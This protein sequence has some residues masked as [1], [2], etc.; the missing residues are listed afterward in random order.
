MIRTHVSVKNITDTIISSQIKLFTTFRHNGPFVVID[1]SRQNESI[2]SSTVCI[3]FECKEN[4]NEYYC[5][6]IHD[7]V[8][9]YNPLT[10]VE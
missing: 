6:I 2:K 5:L 1:C 3:E 4:T 10:N 8:V 9:Q 7:R